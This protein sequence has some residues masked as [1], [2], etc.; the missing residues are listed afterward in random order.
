MRWKS[1]ALAGAAWPTVAGCN[2][3]QEA[4]R[5][6]VNEPLVV[7]TQRS[8]TRDLRSDARAAWREVRA[9]YPRRAFTA[10]FRDGFLDGYVDYLDRGGNGSLP[11]VPPE[12]YTR[13]KKYFTEEGQC[14]VKDYFL[15]FKY[16]QEIAIATGKR[17]FLTV[18]VL[19]PQ[20]PPNPPAFTI[21]PAAIHRLPPPAPVPA[22]PHVGAVPARPA[23]AAQRPAETRVSA[24]PLT[25]P[26]TS[27]V[28]TRV[29]PPPAPIGDVPAVLTPPGSVPRLPPPPRDVPDLPAHVPT[30]SVEDELPVVP[31]DH[32]PPPVVPP[33][34]PESP[35]GE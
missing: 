13:H 31:P 25:L 15:G 7:H 18:P 6:I 33:A 9:D 14:L 8:I 28:G 10:E 20:E 34:R 27:P 22:P 5:N 21:D 23:P 35:R 19:L 3:A 2:L 16:G 29:D 11:A 4:G 24:P 30:P 32:A 1:V 17:Q 26:A 12:K